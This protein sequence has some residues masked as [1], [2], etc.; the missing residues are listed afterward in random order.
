M[1]I[2]KRNI[3]IV[4]DNLVAAKVAKLLLE[5]LGCQVEHVIDGNEVLNLVINKSYHGIYMDIGL[6]TLS[7]VEVCIAIREYESKNKISPL[8]IIAV[9]GN[10]SDAEADQYRTVGMQEVIAKPFSKDKAELFLSFCKK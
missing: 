8:P 7:G 3:L 5:M 2:D 9:T 6:P 1:T 10:F 4:E